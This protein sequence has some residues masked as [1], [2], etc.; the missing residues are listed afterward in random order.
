MW[1]VPF[2]DPAGNGKKIENISIYEKIVRDNLPGAIIMEDDILMNNEFSQLVQMRR[3]FPEAAE[4]IFFVHGKAKLSSF[5]SRK[6]VSDCVLYKC[7]RP[8]LYS[9]RFITNA[10]CYYCSY[11]A[12]K[13]FLEMA[14][15]VRI[16][17]DMLTGLLQRNRLEAFAVNPCCLLG[18]GF[19]SDIGD[20]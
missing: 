6:L 11:S 14:Y 9:I 3:S 4:F 1:H 10:S 2:K 18:A 16:P 20:R 7:L 19:D 15:P 12:A 5:G 17:A 13:R 8:S